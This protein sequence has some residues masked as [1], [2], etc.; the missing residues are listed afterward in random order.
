MSPDAPDGSTSDLGVFGMVPIWVL[1]VEDEK[2]KRLSG[3]ELRV[4]VALRSFA[5]KRGYAKPHVDT[6]AERAGV[7]LRTAEKAISKM[8][9]MKLL[10]SSR[11]YRDDKSIAGCEYWLAAHPGQMDGVPHPGEMD[12]VPPAK[13]T[14]PS[15]P[16]G[17]SKNTPDEHTKGTD[18]LTCT[19]SGRSAPSSGGEDDFATD[20]STDRGGSWR[21]E[22]R[23]R[24]RSYVGQQVRSL[25]VKKWK[26]GLFNTDDVYTALRRKGT[27]PM[28]W[29]G[30]YLQKL[31]KD[32][33]E[34]GLANWLD[35]EGFVLL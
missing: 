8:R 5:N 21:E 31:E 26:P 34:T 30:R 15:R 9:S 2:G 33:G 7:E 22:D 25:G 19:T 4:Y 32:H 3:S 28:E 10:T 20:D 35:D 1:T 23:E 24:F 12:G 17:R 27:K 29:P 18:D 6:I 13:S 11:R 14:G 16:D